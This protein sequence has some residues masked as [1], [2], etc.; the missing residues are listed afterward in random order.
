M[1]IRSSP[2][3]VSPERFLE[4]AFEVA[5][6]VLVFREDDEASVIPGGASHHMSPDPIEQPAD[7][8]VLAAPALLRQRKH[9]VDRG[10]L[11]VELLSARVDRAQRGRGLGDRVLILLDDLFRIFLRQIDRKLLLRLQRVDCISTDRSGLRAALRLSRLDRLHERR[12]VNG[13]RL[14]EGVHRRQQPLL[15]PDEGKLGARRLAGGQP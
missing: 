3:S 12:A 5:A 14:G 2:R 8:R 6:G 7:A 11:G 1:P 9:L 15:Q 13:K 4:T 10:E